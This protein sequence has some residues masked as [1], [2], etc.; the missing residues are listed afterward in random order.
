M[1]GRDNFGVDDMLLGLLLVVEET[2]RQRAL[3]KWR[4]ML[5]TRDMLIFDM[6][7]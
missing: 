4:E 2:D 6:H 1:R 3:D 7:H 5:T